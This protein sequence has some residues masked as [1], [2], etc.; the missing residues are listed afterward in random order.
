[1]LVVLTLFLINTKKVGLDDLDEDTGNKQLEFEY[2]SD[3]SLSLRDD[4]INYMITYARADNFKPE[5]DTEKFN[6]FADNFRTMELGYV[7]DTSR[8][9]AYMD[10]LKQLFASAAEKYSY[11]QIPETAT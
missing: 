3:S 9:V 4:F 10:N 6:Y 5:N 1:M 7:Y 2:K 11:E 8:S